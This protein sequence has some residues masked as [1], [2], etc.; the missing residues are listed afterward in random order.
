VFGTK[1]V[2]VAAPCEIPEQ[3]N[4][5]SEH[6]SWQESFAVDAQLDKKTIPTMHINFI[7]LLSGKSSKN[8]I[9]V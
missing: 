2:P 9:N 7:C 5:L 3:T 4:P 8:L 1:A 6:D